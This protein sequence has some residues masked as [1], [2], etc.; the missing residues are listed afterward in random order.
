MQSF[1]IDFIYTIGK[2]N[3]IY[4]E[5]FLGKYVSFQVKTFSRSSTFHFSS[6]PTFHESEYLPSFD[7]L[8]KN[9][10]LINSKATRLFYILKPPCNINELKDSRNQ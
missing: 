10:Y 3:N 7:I 6:I 9:F 2:D 8:Y 4:F 1:T 5:I